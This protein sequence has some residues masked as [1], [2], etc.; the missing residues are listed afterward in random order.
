MVRIRFPPALSHTN[1]I[2]AT[3]R[4]VRCGAKPWAAG[5]S[6]SVR[7][8]STRCPRPRSLAVLANGGERA[9]PLNA[10][11]RRLLERS[12]SSRSMRLPGPGY[13]RVTGIGASRFR[14]IA[15]PIAR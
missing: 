4:R 8:A 5:R 10:C 15:K 14:S 13:L 9:G 7:K 6:G 3:R 12:G 2:I 1:L 11:L